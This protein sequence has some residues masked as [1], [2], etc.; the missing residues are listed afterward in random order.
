MHVRLAIPIEIY[1]QLLVR[2]DIKGTEY[3]FLKNGIIEKNDRDEKTVVI[4][5]R[6][7]KAANFITWLEQSCPDLRSGIVVEPD[8]SHEC[9]MENAQ[10]IKSSVFSL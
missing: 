8:E 5:S 10:S 9:S 1:D 4:L 6:S 3:R 7:E 2:L